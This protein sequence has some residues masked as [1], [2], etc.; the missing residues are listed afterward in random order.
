MKDK[1]SNHQSGP[2][3]WAIRLLHFFCTPHL[4]EELKGDLDELFQERVQLHGESYAR[5]RYVTDVISLLRPF[6]IKRKPSEYSTL[7][8]PDMLQNYCKIAWRN[9]CLQPGFAF[10]NVSGLAAGL[11]ACLLLVM[12]I[13][14][15]FNYDGFH[16]HS[17]RIVRVVMDYGMDG[18][19]EKIPTTGSRVAPAF[20][21]TFPEV[22]AGV[23]LLNF[24]LTVKVNEQVFNEKRAVFADSAFFGIF[25]FKLLSGDAATALAGPDKVVLSASTARRYFGDADPVGKTL[26][27]TFRNDADYTV[28]G[29]VED[30][31]SN[32]QIKYD[33]IPSFASLPAD[34]EELWW[35]ANYITYLLLNSPASVS[36]LQAKIPGYM[37]TQAGETKV[38]GKNYLAFILEPLQSVHLHSEVEGGLEPNGNLTYLIMFSIIA[39]LILGIAVVNYINLAT[40]KAISRAHEVGVRKMMGAGRRQLFGQFVG[41]SILV[42]GAAMAIAIVLI[43]ELLPWFSQLTGHNFSILSWVQPLPMIVLIT[44]GITVALLAGSYPAVVLTRFQPSLVLRGAVRAGGGNLRRV[45]IVSQFAIAVFLIISTLVVSSQL[46]YIQSKPLGYDKDHVLILPADQHVRDKIK[47]IKSEFK[48]NS[49]VRSVAMANQSPVFIEGGYSMRKPSMPENQ[50]KMVTALPVDEDFIKTVGL[51]ILEGRELTAEDYLQATLPERSQQ[52]QHYVLNE[53]AVKEL[54]WTS[55]QAIGQKLIMGG[56][57]GEITAVVRDF[58]F[59]S[60]RHE[61]GPLVIFP[62]QGNGVVLV[63]VSGRNM[64][65]TLQIMQN[66][67][68]TLVPDSPFSYQFMDDEFNRLYTAEN[69]TGQIFRIF[70]GLSIALACLGLLGLSAYTTSQRT[71]EIGVRKVLGASVASIVA[72]LSKDFLRLVM[73]SIVLGAPFAWYVMNQW[74]QDFAYR[75]NIEWWIFAVSGLL[76]AGIALLTISFQSVKAALLNPVKSLKNE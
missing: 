27:L 28:T 69:R 54:G 5:R 52:Y 68:H 17:D 45:L 8:L 39:V 20:K 70:A 19:S 23:R 56:Y 67:W 57:P 2:P 59:A 60:M 48:Q 46:N 34:K 53:S 50:K 43:S 32:S 72:L 63:N 30:S 9:L 71:K 4:I 11:A 58:H 1:S 51:Q 75:V 66:Q 37:K 33:L 6:A 10:I 31:P 36:A 24:P 64:Q 73:I 61:I 35:E 41:E 22:E 7:T 26:R 65:Q 44:G 29:V 3:K 38:T 42:T 40:A 15:E 74:L 55:R 12:Y 25:S 14:H 18:R 16:Q 76:A 13:T 21:R 49:A 62:D 47:T